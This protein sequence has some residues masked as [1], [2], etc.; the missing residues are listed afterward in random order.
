MWGLGTGSQQIC[1]RV[2][3]ARLHEQEVDNRNADVSET[4]YR[5]IVGQPPIRFD[6][7]QVLWRKTFILLEAKLRA[8]IRLHPEVG[9]RME[10]DFV[11]VSTFP[12]ILAFATVN[13][14]FGAERRGREV[15]GS[16]PETGC[17][18]FLGFPQS[19]QARLP[20]PSQFIIHFHPLVRRR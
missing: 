6:E 14:C 18:V 7:L 9:I 19:L 12:E 3:K 1:S 8:R 17:H 10:S 16:S 2:S 11:A 15:P 13:L 5:L 4:F 20:H